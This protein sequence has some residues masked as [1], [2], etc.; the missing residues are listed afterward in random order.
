MD[1]VH[2][3]IAHLLIIH[4]VC[5]VTVHI[6]YDVC[7][8]CTWHNLWRERER[9][10]DTHSPYVN[11]PEWCP[12]S[13]KHAILWDQTHT[14]RQNHD[15]HNLPAKHISSPLQESDI[16]G[17]TNNTNQ[18]SIPRHK[19]TYTLSKS[20]V[21]EYIIYTLWYNVLLQQMGLKINGCNRER[22]VHG[23]FKLERCVM[24]AWS[25]WL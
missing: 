25:K 1:N 5:M 16:I 19:H 7:M 8:P 24:N 4:C 18:P 6:L 3:Y 20:M 14:Q 13:L 17:L 15:H 11:R 2:V 22:G 10:T 21:H 23:C 12:S 9:E